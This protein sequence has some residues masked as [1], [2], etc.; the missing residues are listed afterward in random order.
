MLRPIPMSILTAIPSV[1]A[2]DQHDWCEGWWARARHCPSP[3]FGPRPAGV[4]PSLVIVHS[5]SLPPGVYGGDEVERFFLNQLD[6]SAHAYF[7]AL[8]DVRVSAHFFIRRD[9]R[10]VQFVS[11]RERA[12][13]A[14]VSSWRGRSNCNDYSVGVELEGLEGETFETAQ[15]EALCE[16]LR[17]LA[18]QGRCLDVAGH[19][20][21][22]A[23]RK[24]DP[25]PGF[26]WPW[27]IARLGWP[28]QCF[29]EALAASDPDCA[30]SS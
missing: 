24:G 13:H 15:Y 17:A 3:N 14:G 19:E 26:D 8:H 12:W 22:S 9:G 11:S 16:L 29:P 30:A 4:E 25:G 20:H 6:V 7:A 28:H 10:C 1:A 23:G 18:G 5:I 27:L 21:V 2:P